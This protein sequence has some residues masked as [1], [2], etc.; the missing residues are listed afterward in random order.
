VTSLATDDLIAFQFY[1]GKKTQRMFARVLATPG[2]TVAVRGKRLL[3][4]GNEAAD[5][6]RELACI[7]AGLTVPRETVLV[8][9][10]SS[11][12]ELPLSKRLVP[13]HSIIGRITG[14]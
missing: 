6:P 3:V 10:D 11:N 12:A 1:D 5:L 8:I 7:G 14:R 2:M 13:Y 9:F 4:E